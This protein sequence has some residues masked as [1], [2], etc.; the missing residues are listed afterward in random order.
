M[1]SHLRPR[2][3]KFEIFTAFVLFVLALMLLGATSDFIYRLILAGW[4]AAD[5]LFEIFLPHP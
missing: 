1:N 3:N 2:A 4:R 5:F